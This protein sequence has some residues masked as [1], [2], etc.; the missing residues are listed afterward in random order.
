MWV[1]IFIVLTIICFYL[2][3]KYDGAG[4]YT[5]CLP[6]GIACLLEYKNFLDVIIGL[7]LIGIGVYF[8]YMIYRH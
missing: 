4:L 1:I 8:F 3:Y 7:I 6:A 2:L 5:F